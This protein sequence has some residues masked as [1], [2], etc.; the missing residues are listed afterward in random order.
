MSAFCHAL[1]RKKKMTENKTFLSDLG[2]RLCHF[3]FEFIV[4]IEA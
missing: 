3:N 4:I 2:K 1:F